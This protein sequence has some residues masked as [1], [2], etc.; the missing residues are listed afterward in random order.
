MYLL[1]YNKYPLV[2]GFPYL[3]DGFLL[4]AWNTQLRLPLHSTANVPLGN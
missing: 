2:N 3:L 1:Y 4:Q